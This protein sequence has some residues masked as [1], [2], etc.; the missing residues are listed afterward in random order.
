VGNKYW[1]LALQVGGVS[2]IETIKYA[3]E[4]RGTHLR[5]AALTMP[6]K[7]LKLQ[8]RLLVREGAPHQQTRN[9][10]K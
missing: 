2:K 7:N 5:K 1:N 4:F 9:C 3:H 8:I 6:G 10:L